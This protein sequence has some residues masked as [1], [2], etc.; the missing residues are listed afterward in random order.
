MCL[1]GASS[2]LVKAFFSADLLYTDSKLILN[3]TWRSWNFGPT[4][5]IV[6]KSRKRD[7]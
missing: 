3:E 2:K 5:L 4:A 1:S 6:I 7:F